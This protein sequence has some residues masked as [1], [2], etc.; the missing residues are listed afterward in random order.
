MSRAQQGEGTLG[1]HLSYF[2]KGFS[3]PSLPQLVVSLR[4]LHGSG[5]LS[6]PEI[7]EIFEEEWEA[8]QCH[9]SLYD[10]SFVLASLD[11]MW[12]ISADR[13]RCSVTTLVRLQTLVLVPPRCLP[14]KLCAATPFFTGSTTRFLPSQTV[15]LH[16]IF[17]SIFFSWP[18]V[19]HKLVPSASTFPSA[20]TISPSTQ[21]F[22]RSC[23]VI[24]PLYRYVPGSGIGARKLMLRLAV[25]NVPPL[26]K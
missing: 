8:A 15:S 19:I 22:L 6:R 13:H 17:A 24:H 25:Y 3:C 7:A 10:Q 5:C 11:S 26:V 2:S 14:H 16:Q 21:L 18:T 1:V 12:K 4:F 23:F 20:S 9:A